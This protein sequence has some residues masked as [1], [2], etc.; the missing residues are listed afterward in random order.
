MKDKI[1]SI[2]NGNKIFKYFGIVKK[3]KI[4]INK[5]GYTN[6]SV[7]A[8]S[9]ENFSVSL[10]ESIAAGLPVLCVN[11]Q[12][13]NSVLGN[14]AFYYNHNSKKDFQKQL[15]NMLLNKKKIKEK[16]ST[17]VSHTKKYLPK[18]I[19]LKTYNFLRRMSE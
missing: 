16:I 13:M 3:E 17:Y 6:I 8:S 12:P 2:K 18:T 14:R 10:I 1:N 4:Y 15:L 7:F 5:K 9:C 19:A 11:L